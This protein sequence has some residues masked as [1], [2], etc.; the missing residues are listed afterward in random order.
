MQE[1]GDD[2]RLVQMQALLQWTMVRLH[3][4]V[5]VEQK[6]KWLICRHLQA[7]L[8]SRQFICCQGFTQ[9]NS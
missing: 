5:D 1:A 7:G 3:S 2:L 8:R 9:N 6:M 4:A